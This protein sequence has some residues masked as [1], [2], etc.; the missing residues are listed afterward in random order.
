MDNAW[1]FRTTKLRLKGSKHK[2]VQ[3][4]SFAAMQISLLGFYACFRNFGSPAQA[5]WA[6][7]PLEF[8]NYRGTCDESNQ[9]FE[10]SLALIS[11]CL[12]ELKKDFP[13][14]EEVALL[15]DGPNNFF[16]TAFVF[17]LPIL[18]AKHGIKLKEQL[19]FESGGGKSECDR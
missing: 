11:G 7:V 12:V 6:N 8:V 1:Q 16:C 13:F 4:D 17:A 18:F 5:S 3:S 15:T 14:I 9:D 10:Q 2:E 19:K